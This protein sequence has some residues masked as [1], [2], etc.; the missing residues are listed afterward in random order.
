[1]ATQTAPA[2]A[3]LF[4]ATTHARRW[5]VDYCAR[6]GAG[7]VLCDSDDPA[8]EAMFEELAA[9]ASDDLGHARE[10]VQRH[11]ADIGTGF[12]IIGEA[13]ERPWP[14]S[15]VPLLIE[16]GEW[17]GLAAGIVQRAELMEQVITDLYCDAKLV[18][19]GLL[20]A[21]LVAG[22]PLY[23]RPMV[24]MPPPGGGYPPVG[25]QPAKKSP[26]LIIGIVVAA[27]VLLAAVG[28]IIMVLNRDPQGQPGPVSITPT[29]PVPP[30]VEPTPN[31]DPT[32]APT[33]TPSDPGGNP[34][35]TPT[36]PGNEP[37]G[38]DAIDLGSGI[39]LTPASGWETQKTAKGVA[40]LSD[41]KS[42]FLGQVIQA[43]ASTNPGQLC[44]AWHR[45]IAEGTSNGKF[46]DP[47]SADLG[48]KKLS[49]GTCLAQ[50]T[51][52]NGQGSSTVLL[53]SLVSVRTG[54][55][56][57]VLGTA[58]FPENADAEQLNKDFSTM[59]NS[60]LEGQAKG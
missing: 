25:G 36:D 39:S 41:G 15:P 53:F 1:M 17:A 27:L 32:P 40:Q 31:G 54:D 56:V 26:G 29:E 28:G 47:K 9:V 34:T 55:G 46:Q 13:D 35:P 30:S 52:S 58:S 59:I 57:T 12:R 60:M 21:A 4:D 24:G 22:S 49:A 10:R 5:M 19:N 3:P 6:R 14:V 20:P 38:G 16:H 33:P 23:L 18:E 43:E 42:V 11:A 51:V 48:T 50:I 8:W 37:S 45:K 44:D 2:T 7:D